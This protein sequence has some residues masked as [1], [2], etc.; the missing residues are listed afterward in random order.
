MKTLLARVRA[1]MHI[2]ACMNERL[3]VF[4]L[5]VAVVLPTH[6]PIVIQSS[7][8]ALHQVY[9]LKEEARVHAKQCVCC[10]RCLSSQVAQGEHLHSLC[11]VAM[12]YVQ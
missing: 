1:C 9:D 3:L 6:L 11:V 12:C 2:L 5:Q 4:F 8:H 10:I 7:I